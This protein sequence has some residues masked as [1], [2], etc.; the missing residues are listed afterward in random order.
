M[1][2]H[3][4]HPK[5]GV[6]NEDVSCTGCGQL[7]GTKN[8]KVCR[9]CYECSHCCGGHVTKELVTAHQFITV[10]LDLTEGDFG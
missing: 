9:V 1:N 7:Y 3:N 8:R 4:I 5:W 6:P 2:P 10:D